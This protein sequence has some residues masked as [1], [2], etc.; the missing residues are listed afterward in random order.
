VKIRR[1]RRSPRELLTFEVEVHDE[2]FA[3]FDHSCAG[4]DSHRLLGIAL[5]ERERGLL[6]AGRSV[7][8]L[9][10]CD[11]CLWERRLVLRLAD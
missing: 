3:F 2:P 4:A 11:Q 7:A 8:V 5:S 10:A 1:H 9:V 6:R